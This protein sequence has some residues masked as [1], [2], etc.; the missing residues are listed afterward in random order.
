LGLN[1]YRDS[2]WN[3]ISGGYKTRFE[4]A[5]AMVCKPKLL[6]LDEPLAPLDVFAQK[7]FL[8]DLRDLAASRRAP[9]PMVI[10]SQHLYEIELIAS[11]LIF[12][13]KGEVAYLGCPNAFN[14]PDGC[15]LFEIAC[16]AEQHEL[17]NV[18]LDIDV[19]TVDS[20]GMRF[21]VRTPNSLDGN[22]LLTRLLS[23]G[24]SIGF[25]HDLTHSTRRL[26][27]EARPRV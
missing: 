11:Q 15:N 22:T 21:L 5:R 9:L 26:F 19:C 16:N 23:H 1:C 20:L 3:E 8:E 25:F 18:L 13:R 4:L 14:S 10:S 17:R 27:E 6:V 7:T 12:L 2:T 24:F